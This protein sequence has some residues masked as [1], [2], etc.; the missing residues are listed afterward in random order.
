MKHEGER[1]ETEEQE[2]GDHPPPLARRW[3][4]GPEKAGSWEGTVRVQ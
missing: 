2:L 4:Y 3:D 1:G